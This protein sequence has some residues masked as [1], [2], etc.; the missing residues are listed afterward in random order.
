MKNGE[1]ERLVTRIRQL[2]QTGRTAEGQPPS[3]SSDPD[4]AQV[5][6]LERRIAHLEQ[7]LEG[8]QDSVHRE[9]ER[10]G[11]R[12]AELEARIEPGALGEA[13]SK[14]ARERGL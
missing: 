6:R 4:R 7:L 14:D 11:K 2:R 13:M 8:L 1:R 10:Q 3:D 12:I 5:V 9:S